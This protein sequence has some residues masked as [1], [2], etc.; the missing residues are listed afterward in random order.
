MS[1]P[2]AKGLKTVTTYWV[3]TEC[4][5]VGS[6]QRFR[7][8]MLHRNVDGSHV[9]RTLQSVVNQKT[10]IMNSVP[11]HPV[12]NH[13]ERSLQWRVIISNGISW[14]LLSP[15]CVGNLS[16]ALKW[17]LHFARNYFDVFHRPTWAFTLRYHFPER[18]GSLF[19]LHYR[20][21]IFFR[22]FIKR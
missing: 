8:S 22:C 19:H 11:V 6:Y 1:N 20:L 5:L 12:S 18:T 7:N 9:Y 21:L 17:K 14:T 3:L 13:S 16:S 2:G 15:F 4:R 10:I